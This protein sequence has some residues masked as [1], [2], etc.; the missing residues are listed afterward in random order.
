MTASSTGCDGHA[1]VSAELRAV[2]VA[3]LDRLEPWLDRLRVEP[4]TPMPSSTCAHCPVCALV[5]VLR[6][7]HPELV[8]RLAEQVGG[9]VTL[10]RE[11]VA[12]TD[13]GPE[14]TASGSPKLVQRIPV[15]RVG[16][17]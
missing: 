10:L 12:E 3:A 5:A 8:Q 16:T 15:E 17:R 9:F 2:A 11:A 4:P 6:G 14:R 1:G 13:A 7:E